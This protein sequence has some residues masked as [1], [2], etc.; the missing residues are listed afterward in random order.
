[1]CFTYIYSTRWDFA[2]ECVS[3]SNFEIMADVIVW[4]CV[5]YDVVD[6]HYIHFM[7]IRRHN[8]D[9]NEHDIN[10]DH[11][12]LVDIVLKCDLQKQP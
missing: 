2:N 8:H 7:A 3:S 12:G 10:S 11:D 5:Y 4:M 1:M 9:N 6:M